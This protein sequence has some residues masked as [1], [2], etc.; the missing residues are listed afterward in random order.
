MIFTVPVPPACVEKAASHYKLDPALLY[1]VI[2]VEHGKNGV[3]IQ[4]DNGTLDLGVMQIN[5]IW[6]PKLSKRYGLT[7]RDLAQKPCLN[8]E[9]GAYILS[10]QLKETGSTW[11]GV[12]YYHSRTKRL[13][14]IYAL[15][16]KRIYYAIKRQWKRLSNKENDIAMK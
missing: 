10:E 15:K 14:R 12:G 13:S 4:N 2:I 6:V 7:A 3:A 1:S 5:T 16:V 9:A 8:V 11:K